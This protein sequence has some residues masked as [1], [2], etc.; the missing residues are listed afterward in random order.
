MLFMSDDFVPKKP[1]RRRMSP[2]TKKLQDVQGATV[3]D[4]L[5]REVFDYWCS[6]M[7]AGKKRLPVFDNERLRCIKWAVGV[8]GVE[9]C[10]RAVDGCALSDWHMGRNP[11]GKRYDDVT[12]IFRSPEHVERFLDSADS[13]DGSGR[14]DW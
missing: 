1:A 2:V 10:R 9:E 4:E 8:Y 12:L 5:A 14:G 6:V 13:S 7:R 11:S 3:V